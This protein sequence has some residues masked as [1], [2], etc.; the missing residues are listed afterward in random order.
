VEI[1]KK[2]KPFVSFI[3]PD[4]SSFLKPDNMPKAIQDFC[5]KTNQK[6]PEGKPEIIRCI[7]ESLSF[8]YRY[9]LD[10]L[11][12]ILN[13]KF[14]ILH[15]VGGGSQNK[16]LCQMTANACKIPVMTG[17]VEA[18]AVGNILMQLLATGNISCIAEGREI[19]KNSFETEILE[20]KEI[21]YYE[22][23]YQKFLSI[24]KK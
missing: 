20:P 10:C 14:E 3:D 17:P 21:D 12:E 16:L 5:K 6:V 15:I 11:S 7:F 13:K 22:S 8:K 19:I 2:A 18:T 1:G 23:V 24:I 9:V 4:D